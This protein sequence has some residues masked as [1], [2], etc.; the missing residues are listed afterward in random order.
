[1]T[2][3]LV[4]VLGPTGYNFAAGMSGGIAYVYD[5]SG[6]FD[7]RCNL[8]TVDL[9]TPWTEQDQKELR[10]VIENHYRN[11]RSA[12]AA[13]ILANWE[14]SVPRFVKVMP[15]DYRKS[16]ERMRFQDDRDRETVSATEEV[17]HG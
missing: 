17:Y 13:K 12:R 9:E 2:G 8:D 15:I 5:E 1:M 7:T 6:T 10:T 3:G 14:A 11:T 16:L 4:V